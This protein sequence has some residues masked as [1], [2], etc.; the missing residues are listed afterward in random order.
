MDDPIVTNDLI[1]DE[2]AAIYVL[3]GPNR[4][5]KS[6]I[7]CAMGL[8][9]VMAQLGLLVPAESAVIS[10]ADAIFTHF[11]TGS[12]DTI[13]K[14]RLGEECSR[15]SDIFDDVS[16]DSLILLDET[17]SSTGSF[18]AAYI[19]SEVLQ[20]FSMV[21]CRGIFA[22]HLHDLAASV[23]TINA[24]ALPKGGV[25]I[26]NLVAAIDQGSRSFKIRR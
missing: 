7:T 15:L 26:D 8:A 20:G 9:V 23:D 5:G 11:P 4:G 21:K 22:T 10:P 25:K 14:G 18:E 16:E 17:L 1:F 2:K 24:A 19:A 3:T 13:N 6:V 12:E